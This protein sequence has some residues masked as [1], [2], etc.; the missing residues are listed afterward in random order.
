MV[1]DASTAEGTERRRQLAEEA[2]GMPLPP[3]PVQDWYFIF[4]SGHRLI[5]AMVLGEEPFIRGIPLEDRYV[6]IRGTFNAAREQ[7]CLI[8]G[9]YW[10]DQCESLPDVSGVTWRELEI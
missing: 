7:M 1:L 4:G 5:P 6:V 3:E 9:I 8:F 2:L 10:S